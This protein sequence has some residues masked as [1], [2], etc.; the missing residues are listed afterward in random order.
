VAKRHSS[1]I[2]V[3][4]DKLFEFV[5]AVILLRNGYH[6]T[7]PKSRLRGR[8]S[9]HQI[10]SI[11][12]Y[13]LQL[14][15]VFPIRLVA[16]AKCYG[17][18]PVGIDAVRNIRSVVEDLNQT[19]PGCVRVPTSPEDTHSSCQCVGALFSTNGFSSP[20]YEYACSHGVFCVDMEPRVQGDAEVRD[21]SEWMHEL[22]EQLW[23]MARDRSCPDDSI[24]DP[25]SYDMIEKLVEE[26]LAALDGSERARVIRVI[27]AVLNRCSRFAELW[28]YLSTLHLGTFGGNAV[29]IRVSAESL[30]LITEDVCGVALANAQHAAAQSERPYSH[31]WEYRLRLAIKSAEPLDTREVDDSAEAVPR[32]RMVLSWL[33]FASDEVATV[34][35]VLSASTLDPLRESGNVRIVMPL[36]ETVMLSGECWL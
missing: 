12:L 3:S 8:G 6:A 23:V 27:E 19:L 13:R 2:R 35:F 25:A 32:R 31:D 26:G 7:V 28:R 24:H 30:P 5:V 34:D 10:D 33:S 17:A 4:I 15:F 9:R 14:P 22:A 11:G 21:M 36:T 16:E 29:M 18:K 1:D 20:A